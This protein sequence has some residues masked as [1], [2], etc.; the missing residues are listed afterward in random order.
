MLRK[1]ALLI[2]VAMIFITGCSSSGIEDQ[3]EE[4]STP[5][6]IEKIESGNI[7]NYSKVVGE[8]KPNANISVSP[9]TPGTVKEVFVEIGD[10]VNKG[11]ILF[12]ID[13]ED[14]SLQVE[15]A[16][17]GFEIAQASYNI[18]KGGSTQLQLNQYESNLKVS[19]L[20]VRDAK[21]RYEDASKLYQSSAIPKENYESIQTAYLSVLEQYNNAK[22]SLE[23]NKTKILNENIGIAEAQLTQA[24]ASYAMA[25]KSLENTIVTSPIDGV[26]SSQNL[27][28]GMQVSGATPVLSIVDISSVYVDIKVLESIYTKINKDDEY[29]I[30][31]PSL[32]NKTYKGKVVSV[33]PNIDERTGTYLIKLSIQNHNEQLKGGMI[34][35]VNIIDESKEN[36]IIVPIDAIVE[37]GTE[38]SIFIVKDNI[39]KKIIVSTGI[40]SDDKIEISGSV[41]SSD[42]VVVRG[43]TFLE[44]NDKVTVVENGGE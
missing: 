24:S 3:Q 14:I 6:S 30:T 9:K 29:D 33:S 19:E 7:N 38:K 36:V 42:N 27:N 15:Q 32:G 11:D 31:V 12:A 5:V 2:F 25:K 21:K 26:I 4:K 28:I 22:L 20:N 37:N 43:Q 23:L 10:Y 8:V 40:I 35:E 41:K 17:A 34:A 44:D 16:R 13:D 18:A 1:F 39:A